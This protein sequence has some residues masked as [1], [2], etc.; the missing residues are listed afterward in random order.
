[1]R[2]KAAVVAANS[3]CS[4]IEVAMVP[5]IW[6]LGT[7]SCPTEN[8]SARTGAADCALPLCSVDERLIRLLPPLAALDLAH[9]SWS[10]CRVR[11]V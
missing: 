1:M 2:D 10:R 8:V 7:A 11:G 9:C 3:L 4:A 5:E 6:T